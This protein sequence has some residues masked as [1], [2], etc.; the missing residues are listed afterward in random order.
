MVFSISPA[1]CLTNKI[2]KQN[3]VVVV[4][5]A[6]FAGYRSLLIATD[7]LL[8]LFAERGLSLGSI[9]D[10]DASGTSVSDAHAPCRAAC[11]NSLIRHTPR[12]SGT[13]GS[14]FYLRLVNGG[15]IKTFFTEVIRFIWGWGQQSY[16]GEYVC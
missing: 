16:F 5:L 15:E 11:D 3:F 6:C 12:S 8:P 4:L 14:D 10:N 9:E 7:V 13:D 2:A 1:V